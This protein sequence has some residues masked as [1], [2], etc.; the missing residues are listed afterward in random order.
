MCTSS[1]VARSTA[2]DGHCDFALLASTPDDLD[3]AAVTVPC[4]GYV[5]VRK[6]GNA[7]SS[8]DDVLLPSD[9]AL[10]TIVLTSTTA[11]GSPEERRDAD[12]MVNNAASQAS[13]LSWDNIP[14]CLSGES[15]MPFQFLPQT[16]AGRLPPRGGKSVCYQCWNR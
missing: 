6:S 10:T 3:G 12:L 9:S 5:T 7:T 15:G 14:A 16:V 11:A 4:R 2:G 8:R 1:P 13:N